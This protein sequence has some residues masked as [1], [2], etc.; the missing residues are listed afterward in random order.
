MRGVRKRPNPKK[1]FPRLLAAAGSFPPKRTTGMR[2]FPAVFMAMEPNPSRTQETVEAKLGS[3]PAGRW[4][5]GGPEAEDGDG[6]ISDLVGDRRRSTTRF[7]R[8]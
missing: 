5:G 2:V 4:P 7:C 8:T 1:T 3:G 6:P